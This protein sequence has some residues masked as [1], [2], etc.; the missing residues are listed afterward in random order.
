MAAIVIFQPGAN[1]PA[2]YQIEDRPATAVVQRC[3]P[4]LIQLQNF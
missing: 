3:R 2:A 4:G 1:L